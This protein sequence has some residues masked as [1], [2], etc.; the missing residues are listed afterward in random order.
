MNSRLQNSSQQFQIETRTFPNQKNMLIWSS[1]SEYQT[2]QMAHFKNRTIF[3]DSATCWATATLHV[4][5]QFKLFRY[6]LSVTS[7]FQETHGILSA[8]KEISQY[9]SA[10]SKP[11]TKPRMDIALHN[12][13]S[14][15]FPNYGDVFD[16][17][18]EDTAELLVIGQ[19]QDATAF[20]GHI[21]SELPFF[22][23]SEWD[24]TSS[25]KFFTKNKE[26][27]KI[28]EPQDCITSIA[29]PTQVLIF[30]HFTKSLQLGEVRCQKY[31]KEVF[32]ETN[33]SGFDY[34]HK[35]LSFVANKTSHYYLK[36]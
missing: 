34:Q 26:L 29:A 35:T 27:Q 21:A 24:I 10:V 14:N 13:S 30:R 19:Y 3:N 23:E 12:A 1:T 32:S 25:R 16:Q 28:L 36:P 20:Y 9:F 18:P 31:D 6:R 7:E 15:L 8:F 33:E 22:H 17:S 5:L 11:T 2:F 4:L